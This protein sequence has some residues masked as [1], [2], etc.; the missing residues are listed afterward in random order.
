M[1]NPVEPE[2]KETKAIERV[3]IEELPPVSQDAKA[4]PMRALLSAL[5]VREIT[6]TAEDLNRI[7]AALDKMERNL[8]GLQDKLSEQQPVVTKELREWYKNS[9]IPETLKNGQEQSV[10]ALNNMEYSLRQGFNSLREKSGQL[11]GKTDSFQSTANLPAATYEKPEN[12]FSDDDRPLPP[13]QSANLSTQTYYNPTEVPVSD[14]PAREL[15]VDIFNEVSQP[16]LIV[17]AEHPALQPLSVHVTINHDILTI[18]AADLAGQTYA[19]EILLPLP[20]EIVPT[21]QSYRNGVLEIK[22]KKI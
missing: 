7:R 20:V 13:T 2:T 12:N 21:G 11:M 9:G 19:K 8:E 14:A 6:G 22:L 5:V 1:S 4:N 16:E 17:V 15:H 10:Q 3:E 18:I